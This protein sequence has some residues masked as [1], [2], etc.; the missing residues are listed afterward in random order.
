M[1]KLFAGAVLTLLALAGVPLRAQQAPQVPVKM[2]VVFTEFEGDK[3]ISSQPYTFYVNAGEPARTSVRVGVRVPIY[4][5]GKETQ[6]QFQYTDI[7]TNIDCKVIPAEGGQFRTELNLERSSAYSS[8]GSM[9][10]SP[11]SK[12]ELQTAKIQPTLRTFRSNVNLMLRDGQT[13]QSNM[14]TDPATGR[15]LKVDV[16]LTVVK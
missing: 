6:A 12:A 5:G 2:Q 16:T 15:V 4:T 13:L 14:A 7:G 1:K 10:N 8:S 11:E 9:D 3:K